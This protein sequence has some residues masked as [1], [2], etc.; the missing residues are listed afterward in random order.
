MKKYAQKRL[1]EPTLLEISGNPTNQ[2][3]DNH[4]RF[5]AAASAFHTASWLISLEPY[6]P[7]NVGSPLPIV[8]RMQASI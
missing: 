5:S 4:F 2:D 7:W 8:I 3:L 1:T 6:E